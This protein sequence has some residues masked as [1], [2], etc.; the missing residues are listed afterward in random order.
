[1]LVQRLCQARAIDRLGH[2]YLISGDSPQALYQFVLAWIQVCLC[3]NS[4]PGGDACGSCQTCDQVIGHRY[5]Y[6]HELKPRSK[7]RAI[8]IDVIRELEGALNIKSGG[9]MRV[10]VIW[11]ADCMQEPAQSAF[12]KT[13]EEP[14]PNTLLLLVTARPE[15]L[16]A[17]IRSRCQTIAL[18]E[19]RFDPALPELPAVYANLSQLR[20]GRGAAVACKVASYLEAF[21]DALKVVSDAKVKQESAALQKQARDGQMTDVQ[22]Q[23]LETEMQA[24]SAADYLGA[25]EQLLSAIY[26]WFAQEYLRANSVPITSMPNPEAYA[27]LPVETRESAISEGEARHNL[28]QTL[29]FIR[30]MSFNV[31]EALAVQNFCQAVCAKA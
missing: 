12:L 2:A 17:T 5:H 8:T 19:N 21:S 18:R 7:S 16:L 25:R 30:T 9:A 24:A 23:R 31:D 28:D 11:E 10:A 3:P 26:T 15:A 1:M 14:H 6:M 20:R 13:L 27:E 22:K 4:R 29:D